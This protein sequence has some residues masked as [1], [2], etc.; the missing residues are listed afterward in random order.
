MF[1]N[2]HNYIV[3]PP[4]NHTLPLPSDNYHHGAEQYSAPPNTSNAVCPHPSSRFGF[5]NEHIAQ[6]R[7]L[8]PSNNCIDLPLV[9][10][11]HD[12]N[13]A[14]HPNPFD[15]HVRVTAAPNYANGAY[16][17]FK[18]EQLKEVT[19][20]N[21]VLPRYYK[22][23][24]R[25]EAPDAYFAVVD[26]KIAN[27]DTDA[28]LE[29]IIGTTDVVGADT[30]RYVNI[31]WRRDPSPPNNLLFWLVEFIINDD[32]SLLYAYTNDN[33]TTTYHTYQY[34]TSYDAD[35]ER[36]V[37]VQINQLNETNSNATTEEIRNS[38]SV[39][40]P[41]HSTDRHVFLDSCSIK[42]QY[43]RKNI[44]DLS[45]RLLDSNNK[46]LVVNGLNYNITTPPQ[47]VC[48]Y[49]PDGTNTID[50]RCSSHYIRHPYYQYIQTHILLEATLEKQQLE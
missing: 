3:N 42:K 32:P 22:L 30:I 1:R 17:P 48:E 14:I 33:A 41:Y 50:Y 44:T 25:V 11:S 9:L 47:C 23:V 40:Y 49:A 4:L 18:I 39:V 6:H 24:K 21:V 16:V 7:A 37:I 29:A 38:F 43:L 26:A 12:R 28:T 2:N 36:R 45:V 10:D 13:A 5:Y 31:E 19:V 27:T 8:T 34:D 15:Y 20:K 35:R 46:V